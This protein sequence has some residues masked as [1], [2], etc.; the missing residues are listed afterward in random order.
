ML[1]QALKILRQ[2][3]GLTQEELAKKAKITHAYLSMLESGA[4]RNPSLEVLQRLAKALG[5]SVGELLLLLQKGGE[6]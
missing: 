5:V 4:K 3:K 1:T 2:T 6:E